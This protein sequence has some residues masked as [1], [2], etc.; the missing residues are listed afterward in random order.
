MSILLLS[1]RK[2]FD[3]FVI[4][5][6]LVVCPESHIKD[7]SSPL[8][9]PRETYLTTRSRS[10]GVKLIGHYYIENT[11]LTGVL[12]PRSAVMKTGIYGLT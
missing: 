6:G 12:C 1:F 4:D 9:Y 8:D 7:I 11:V 5:F 2:T 3:T 10:A